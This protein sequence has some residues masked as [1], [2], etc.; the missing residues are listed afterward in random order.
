MISSISSTAA[1]LLSGSSTIM[2]SAATDRLLV[3][4]GNSVGDTT[5]DRRSPPDEML[6]NASSPGCTSSPRRN[7]SPDVAG[8]FNNK[9]D[10]SRLSD[11]DPRNH[12][13]N[14][15]SRRCYQSTAES[16]D[17]SSNGS[18]SPSPVLWDPVSEVRRQ[19]QHES[20]G[21]QHNTSADHANKSLSDSPLSINAHYCSSPEVMQHHQHALMSSH[22]A[23]SAAFGRHHQ[24]VHPASHHLHPAAPFHMQTA[25]QQSLRHLHHGLQ[26]LHH[27]PFGPLS[28]VRPPSPSRLD[29]LSPGGDVQR[30]ATV[31][32][33]SSSSPPPGP[34]EKPAKVSDSLTATVTS[35]ATSRSAGTVIDSSNHSP[36]SATPHGIE[37]ILSRPAITTVAR[38]G[39][40]TIGT[41]AQP[42]SSPTAHSMAHQHLSASPPTFPS[43]PQP[44]PSALNFSAAGLAGLPPSSL[45]GVY[46]PAALPGFMANP[47]LQAW[48]DRLHSG[49]ILVPLSL[50]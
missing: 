12:S 43:L 42:F 46:W 44:P 14:S 50:I 41:A 45:A 27:H 40:T 8:D 19:R 20:C 48:R 9:A 34:G 17:S 35:T 30:S 21:N 2:A 49:K 13:S 24:S 18:R 11:E 4:S 38:S 3:A 15:S 7:R 26:G 25:L 1:A 29:M 31:E 22:P 16:S 33:T 37:H 28:A 23:F 36:V 10:V 5:S 32:D 39:C 47:A 6:G